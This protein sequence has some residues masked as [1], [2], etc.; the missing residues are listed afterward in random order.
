MKRQRMCDVVSVKI[1]PDVRFEV[2]KIARRRETGLSDVV[3][4]YLMDG[5]RRD[6]V[7]C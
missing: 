2:E 3:R 5:L 1:S 6:G 4:T 7:T